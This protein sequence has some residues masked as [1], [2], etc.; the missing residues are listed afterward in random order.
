MCYRR[1]PAYVWRFFD[2]PPKFFVDTRCLEAPKAFI[3]WDGY[4]CMPP[5][6]RKVVPGLLPIP[7]PMSLPLAEEVRKL[8]DN[9][10]ERIVK[11]FGNPFDRL[12]KLK[13]LDPGWSKLSPAQPRNW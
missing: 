11:A 4:Y 13:Q 7:K 6:I 5:V 2:T 8:M 1:R 9:Y 12:E 10:K 3:D